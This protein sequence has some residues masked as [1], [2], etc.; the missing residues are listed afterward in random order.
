MAVIIG[1]TGG[2]G[3]GK[4]SAAT[5]FAELGAM[6]IDTD[7][8]AHFLTR[9]GSPTLDK[10]RAELGD[11]VFLPD[12][13]LDRAGLRHR[14]FS[15]SAAKCRLEGILH[16]QIREEVI[17][18]LKNLR[19]DYAILV[20]PLLLE[21]TGYRELVDRVLVIDCPEDR[22]I[23][24]TMARS[25]L[26]ETDV[27]QIMQHQL[28]RQQRLQAADDILDNSSGLAQLRRQVTSLHE[29]FTALASAQIRI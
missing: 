13:Q 14:V 22:Q 24:R 4:S 29:K 18:R 17:S 8:I 15:D 26:A 1:L 10:I 27:R 5:I 2:I 23:E 28:T 6:V 20:V 3:S 12:G 16:P 7:E 21:A 9:P 11:G 19:S 25:K